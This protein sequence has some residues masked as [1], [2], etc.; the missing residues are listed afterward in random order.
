M[1]TLHSQKTCM[2]VLRASNI[3]FASQCG[4]A[5]FVE[6]ARVPIA[7][8]SMLGSNTKAYVYSLRVHQ[9]PAAMSMKN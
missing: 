1:K 8:F 9:K 4:P 6:A 7:A 3:K 5:I 2:V